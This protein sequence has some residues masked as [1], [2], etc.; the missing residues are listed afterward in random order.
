MHILLISYRATDCI[1]GK[2]H[3]CHKLGSVC[4]AQQILEALTM[5]IV[6]ISVCN[7]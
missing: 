5:D 1:M 7:H 3:R 2:I 4:N 6:N